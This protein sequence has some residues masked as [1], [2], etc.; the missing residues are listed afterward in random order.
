MVVK[1]VTYTDFDGNERTEDFLFN[2]TAAQVAEMEWSQDGGLSNLLTRIIK[3]KNNKQL[4][5]LWREFIL[6]AYGVKSADGKKFVKTKEIRD[7]FESSAAFSDI[8][9]ELCTN[10]QAMSDFVNAVIPQNVKG[11]TD[12]KAKVVDMPKA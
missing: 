10:T 5:D 12:D 8:F 6:G 9:M 11:V 2:Y 3:E 4:L 7:D 1:T